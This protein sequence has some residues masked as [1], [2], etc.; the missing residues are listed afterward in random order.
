MIVNK[1]LYI[2]SL[3]SMWN[4]FIFDRIQF[5]YKIAKTQKLKLFYN[6]VTRSNLLVQLINNRT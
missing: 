2:A 1:R 4:L 5:S 3:R 6:I